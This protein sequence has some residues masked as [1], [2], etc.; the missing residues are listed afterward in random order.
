MIISVAVIFSHQQQQENN[1]NI[2]TST[3]NAP[4]SPLRTS[5]MHGKLVDSSH[6]IDELEVQKIHSPKMLF[7]HGR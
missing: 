5:K 4:G 2:L 7:F 1:N 6:D 3:S